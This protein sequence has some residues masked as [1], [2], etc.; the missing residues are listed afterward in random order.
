ML[1]DL[2]ASNHSKQRQKSGSAAVR[3]P[4]RI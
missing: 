4:R 3:R 2:G 1:A